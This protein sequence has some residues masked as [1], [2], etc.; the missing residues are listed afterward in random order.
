MFISN[1]HLECEE[2]SE[3][4]ETAISDI[5]SQGSQECPEEE[6]RG[7][8]Y[9]I[10]TSRKHEIG[11]DYLGYPECWISSCENNRRFAERNGPAY[12]LRYR[13]EPSE[14][15]R[16]CVKFH[17]FNTSSPKRCFNIISSLVEGAFSL[18]LGG[19]FGDVT[20]VWRPTIAIKIHGSLTRDP[21]ILRKR[22]GSVKSNNLRR[23]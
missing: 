20:P 23:E 22:L 11:H 6:K 2:P 16:R 14:H 5:S 19:G 18:T 9:A 10:G 21:I 1:A 13:H 8:S 3:C 12:R 4:T 7:G 17:T 15:L